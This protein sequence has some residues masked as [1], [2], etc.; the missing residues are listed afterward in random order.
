VQFGANVADEAQ[1]AQMGERLNE[2]IRRHLPAE[3]ERAARGLDF[4][5]L[6]DRDGWAPEVGFVDG[7]PAARDGADGPAWMAHCDGAVGAG[8]DMAAD[9]SIGAEL[10]VVTG[11]S[12]R[13]LDRNIAL[14]GRVV[15]GMELLSVLPRGTGPLGFYE[16]PEEATPI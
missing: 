15:K 6:P 1:Q 8:R 14:V 9:S 5:P 7:F 12:P 2:G 3:F 13:Q 4:H 16:T 10:Y 11:Q